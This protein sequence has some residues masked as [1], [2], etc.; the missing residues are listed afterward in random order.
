MIRII[1]FLLLVTLSRA[2]LAASPAHLFDLIDAR[3]ELMHDVA[4]YK[5]QHK[6]PAE[7]KAREVIVLDSA[8][9]A[10]LRRGIKAESSRAFFQAQIDA[11]KEIERYWFSRFKA[12]ESVGSAQD[13]NKTLRPKLLVLGTEI[14][15]ALAELP[16]GVSPLWQARFMSTV[17]VTGLSNASKLALFKALTG[18]SLYANRLQQIFDTGELRVG[19]TGDYPP[20]SHAVGK[21]FVGIDIDMANNLAQALGVHL[22][23]V[24]TSWPNLVKDLNAGRFDIA[25]SGITRNT[26]REKSGFYSVPYYHGGKAAIARCVDAA[27]YS[28]LAAID[29]PEVRVIVNPGGTNERFVK[30]NISRA[31]VIVYPDNTRIFDQILAGKADV[32]I[33]DA[34]EVKLQSRLHSAL[35]PTMP[36]K[37]LTR[38][39][40]AYLMPQDTDLKTYVD[41]W[42]EL[43]VNDGTVARLF[44]KDS[45][46]VNLQK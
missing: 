16:N 27:K 4:A 38:L 22:T 9:S 15:N 29:R 25:M 31:R 11:A 19:T 10:A 41:N 3:L 13:L 46:R 32:M 39:E 36:G 26:Q 45:L 21:R 35:C 12:G 37:T 40:K 23:L 1:C 18:V 14:T 42:L 5:W 7:D 8:A 30:H 6:L 2:V 43:R 28:S 24:R 44:M 17:D 34:I 20:F 33:T